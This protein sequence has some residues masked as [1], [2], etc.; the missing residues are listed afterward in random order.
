MEKRKKAPAGE[1]RAPFGFVSGLLRGLGAAATV[2]SYEFAPHR[3]ASKG[4]RGDWER[5]GKTLDS[6][7][8][9]FDE[10]LARKA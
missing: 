3:Y 6:A 7:I 9:T 1:R 8:R 10:R 5:V 2:N 4:V